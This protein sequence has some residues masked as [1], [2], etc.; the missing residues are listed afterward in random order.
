MCSILGIFDLKQSSEELR[1]VALQMSR[2]Q[3]HRGP[4]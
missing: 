4:D 3:R 1:P 2:K